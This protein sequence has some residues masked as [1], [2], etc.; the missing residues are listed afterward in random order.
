MKRIL[1]LLI[2]ISLIT[3]SCSETKVSSKNAQVVN[4]D[5]QLIKAAKEGNMPAVQY[6]LVNGAE[7]NGKDNDGVTALWMASWKGHT[8]I[9]KFLLK[10]A[11][12]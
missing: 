9:V 3:A 11:L 2:S 6:A 4:G 5:A 7:I 8:E 1:F 12:M 10:K